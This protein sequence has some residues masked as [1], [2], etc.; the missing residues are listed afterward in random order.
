MFTGDP[1]GEYDLR[2]EIMQ[3][4]FESIGV[5]CE[6]DQIF[7][8]AGT[9]YLISVLSTVLLNELS[10]VGFEDL[11]FHRPKKGTYRYKN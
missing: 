9:Q 8:G 2:Y 5:K 3:Y 1:Q 6:P 7:I 4:L 11:G 10:I